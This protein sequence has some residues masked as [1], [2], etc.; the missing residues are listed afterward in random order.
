MTATARRGGEQATLVKQVGPLGINAWRLG[1]LERLADD[2]PAG[3]PPPALA[4]TLDAIEA[5]S[6][7]HP[8]AVVAVAVGLA[9]AAF[10]FL[11]GGNPAGVLAT[12]VAGGVGQLLRS[13]W[14]GQPFNQFAVTA[15]CAMAA[16]GVYCVAA[17]LLARAGLDVGHGIGV[18]AAVLF[19]I[20]GFPL[21]AALLDLLQHQTAAGAVRLAYGMTLLLAAAFGLAMVILVAS[22]AG[23]PPEPR[24]TLPAVWLRP[25]GGGTPFGGGG[26]SVVVHSP[27]RP[28]PGGA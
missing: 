18:V 4:A 8:I 13:L 21:V 12:F 26:S 23:P 11:N 5:A 10:S 14:L 27:P 2:A 16:A 15:L 17:A 22:V 1:S 7:Q 9:S 25:R 19:L 24:G 6:P 28:P 20:P 3:L